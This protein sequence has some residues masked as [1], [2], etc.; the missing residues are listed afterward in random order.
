[1]KLPFLGIL[2]GF[3]LATLGI[4]GAAQAA[5]LLPSLAPGSQYRLLFLTSGTTNATSSDINTYNTFVNNTAQAS[6]VLNAALTAAGF[7]P[8]AINWKALASTTTTN[9]NVNTSLQATDPAFPLYRVDGAPI[10]SPTTVSPEIAANDR[11]FNE[12]FFNRANDLFNGT[13]TVPY[14]FNAINVNE[15]GSNQ[16]GSCGGFGG[17]CA[18]TGF[19]ALGIAAAPLGES[20]PYSGDYN[21]AG[22]NSDSKWR[23]YLQLS[24][25]NQFP[26]YGISSVLTVPTPIAQT[27]PEPSSL[28]GFITLGGLVL[29]GAFRKAKK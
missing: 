16:T 19:N 26:L 11:N 9:A 24:S 15:I 25:T 23:N 20:F 22:D 7:T 14:T 17:N 13:T 3:A 21:N 18:W 8:S 4:S 5:I 2:S 27:T 28:L 10:I 12:L 6:T 29:G 1:M